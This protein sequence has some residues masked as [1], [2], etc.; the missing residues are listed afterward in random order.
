MQPHSI[1]AL[2]S[3]QVALGAYN[4]GMHIA[5]AGCN[6]ASLFWKCWEPPSIFENAL[7]SQIT[8]NS[9]SMAKFQEHY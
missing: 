3:E 5:K 1:T 8:C 9:N 2:N 6:T 7:N 4:G